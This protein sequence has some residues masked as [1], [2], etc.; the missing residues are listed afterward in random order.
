MDDKLM[1]V[2]ITNL[3]SKLRNTVYCTVAKLPWWQQYFPQSQLPSHSADWERNAIFLRHCLPQQDSCTEKWRCIHS[4][5]R[6]ACIISVVSVSTEHELKKWAR[7]LHKLL[8]GPNRFVQPVPSQVCHLELLFLPILCMKPQLQSHLHWS[9]T[10]KTYMSA[11]SY[12]FKAGI[13][14]NITSPSFL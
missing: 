5:S 7:Q 4:T 2:L 6:C 9:Q 3:Q 11:F 12:I 13:V 8:V 1:R 14:K 10:L